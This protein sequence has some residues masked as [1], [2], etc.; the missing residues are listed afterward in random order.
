[1]EDNCIWKNIIAGKFGVSGDGWCSEGI[2]KPCG[3]ELWKGYRERMERIWLRTTT[4]VGSGFKTK[5]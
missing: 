1:M 3:V 4:S 2:G 5:F